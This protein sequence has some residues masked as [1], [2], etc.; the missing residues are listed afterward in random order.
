MPN[1]R[2]WSRTIKLALL[3]GAVG[4]TAACGRD[5]D[6]EGAAKGAAGKE[7]TPDRGGTAII[8]ELADLSKPMP[9]IFD[10]QLDGDLQDVMYMGLTRPAWRDGRMVF[11]TADESPMA[12]A[13][14]YEYLGPDSTALRYHMR[15]DLKWSDGVPITAHDVV[16]SYGSYAD[17]ELGSTRMG[18]VE[19]IDSVVAQ[20]DSTVTFY[21]ERRSPD[22]LFQSGLTIAPRHVYQDTDPAQL[23]NHPA[24]S[25]P[26]EKLVVSGPFRVGRWSPGQQIVLVP[27]PHFP[28]RPNLDRMVIRVIP[29]PTTR[30]AELQTGGVD[31]VYQVPYDQIPR[32]RQQAPNVRF[33]KQEKRFF[34]F[35]AYNPAAHPAFRDPE[36]RRALGLAVDVQGIIRALQMEEYTTPAAGPYSPI[37]E[38]LYDPQRTPLLGHDPERA[39]QILEA[40]GWRDADGDGIREKDGRPLRFTLLTNAGNQRRADVSQILQQQ[41]KQVGA[42]VRL[43]QLEFNTF[44]ERQVKEEYD[45]VLG[46]WGVQLSPDLTGL[47]APDA[48]FNIVSYRNPEAAR[49]MEQAKAQPTAEKANPYWRAAAERIVQDQPYTWLYFYDTV[50]ALND[51]LRNVEVNPY[52]AFQNPWEWW[53]PKDRQRGAAAGAPAT[54]DTMR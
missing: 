45:A 30:L 36:I 2:N 41:W 38:D 15:S 3:L 54:P 52:G 8:A 51:R 18:D 28:V 23:R 9:L 12:M 40:K 20:D 32:L 6:G 19:P 11:L 5:D 37:M 34:E 22:M 4:W 14:G 24:L 25:R 53:I 33:E 46:G 39:R 27:N 7:G 43:Q 26:A 50:V 17:P 48:D 1:A 47:W 10:T 44:M 42:D 35:I 21:F 13:R 31:F 29:E 16:W 49:L